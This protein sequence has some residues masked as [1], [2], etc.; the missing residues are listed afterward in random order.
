MLYTYT[1]FSFNLNNNSTYK[2]HCTALH[3]IISKIWAFVDFVTF[4]FTKKEEEVQPAQFA[5]GLCFELNFQK[6]AKKH[7]QQVGKKGSAVLQVLYYIL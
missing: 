7:F 6:W 5:N 1:L 3:Y 4:A 2:E